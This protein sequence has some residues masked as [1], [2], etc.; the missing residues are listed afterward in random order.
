MT[1]QEKREVASVGSNAALAARDHRPGDYVC[2]NAWYSLCHD[3]AVKNKPLART[4]DE[5]PVVV[6]RDRT[7]KIVV[8][9]DSCLHRRVPLSLGKIA[10]GTLQCPYH[11]WS[12]DSRGSCVKIPSLGPGSTPNSRFVLGTYPSHVRYGLVWVWYGDPAATDTD[13]IPDIPFL[14]PNRSAPCERQ[15]VYE[16]ASEL[17]VEN[18]LDLTHLD[19]LHGRIIGDPGGGF[20]NIEESATDE[21]V[22]MTRLSKDRKPPASQAPFYGFPKQ[23]DFFQMTLTYVR[24]GACLVSTFFTP[25]GWNISLYLPCTPEGPNRTRMDYSMAITGPWWYQKIFPPLNRIIAMQDHRVL[26]VQ[27]PNYR[28]KFDA[29]DRDKSVPADAPGLRYRQVR[30]ALIQRQMAGD[31]AYRDGWRGKDPAEVLHAKR[32]G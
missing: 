26:R 32:L 8:Q 6:W 14:H 19:I 4:L 10:D 15:L 12:Y 7:G 13:L 16:A 20:E 17:A 28:R 30:R 11:G 1:L 24:T 3:S 21:V 25:P 27:N 23:Q 29:D 31:M 2:R 5:K 18:L 9:D 22:T